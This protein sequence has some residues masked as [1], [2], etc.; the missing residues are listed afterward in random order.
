MSYNRSWVQ[1]FWVQKKG[2]ASSLNPLSG[3]TKSQL[4]KTLGIVL[5]PS[6]LQK[7]VTRAAGRR[8]MDVENKVICPFQ[9]AS[10]MDDEPFIPPQFLLSNFKFQ[11]V[12]GYGKSRLTTTE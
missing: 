7:H 2:R 11:A 8:K 6:P 10:S 9:T 5:Y 12:N 1:R 3:A 4:D